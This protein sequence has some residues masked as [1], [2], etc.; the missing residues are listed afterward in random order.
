MRTMLMRDRGWR[1][2]GLLKVLKLLGRGWEW[3]A[4]P[5]QRAT[6]L[7]APHGQVFRAKPKGNGF[8]VCRDERREQQF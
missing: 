5:G 8:E 1:R 6:H 3:Q 7:R 2:V 4:L